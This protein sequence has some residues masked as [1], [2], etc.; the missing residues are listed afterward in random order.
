MKQTL[1]IILATDALTLRIMVGLASAG[2]ARQHVLFA[3][4]SRNLKPLKGAVMKNGDFFK[5][6]CAIIGF[7]YILK[8]I[9]LNFITA[10]NSY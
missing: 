4:K 5:I 2:T 3:E 8:F 1:S 9:G 10:A 7:L 6:V